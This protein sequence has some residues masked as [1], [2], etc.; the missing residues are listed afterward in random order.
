MQCLLLC[1]PP[2]A[3]ALGKTWCVGC[4]SGFLPLPK[5]C[6]CSYPCSLISRQL[7]RCLR[8]GLLRGRQFFVAALLRGSC[9]SEQWEDLLPL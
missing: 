7:L 4:V 1:L 2:S 6:Q 3:S 9:F 5:A 8:E